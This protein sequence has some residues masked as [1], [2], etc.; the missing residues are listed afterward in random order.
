[1][2]TP[3]RQRR[4]AWRSASKTSRP[5]RRTRQLPAGASRLLSGAKS[6]SARSPRSTKRKT[7]PC[8][9]CSGS[10]MWSRCLTCRARVNQNPWWRPWWR[11]WRK[12]MKRHPSRRR[13]RGTLRKSSNLQK[14]CEG[15]SPTS[16][17]TASSEVWTT[18]STSEGRSGKKKPSC[19]CRV[20]CPCLLLRGQS[21]WVP[22]GQRRGE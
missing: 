5:K 15:L 2:R 17:S 7:T 22:E 8:A 14:S 16:R 12:R 21:L 9:T 4:C 11:P 1:M 13:D 6:K 18:H 10:V 19:P 20:M 3:Q